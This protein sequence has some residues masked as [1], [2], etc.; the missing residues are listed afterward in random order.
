[1]VDDRS[2][3]ERVVT[4]DLGR[5][6]GIGRPLSER[7]RQTIRTV[8]AYLKGGDPPRWMQRL[9]EIDR[10]IVA[11]RQ[12]LARAYRALQRDCGHDAD[13]FACRWL[14]LAQS[15]KFD[16]LNELIG[17]HNDWYPIER[18]LP[19]DPRTGDYVKIAGR[20]YRRAPLGPAWVLQHFPASTPGDEG[21]RR[22]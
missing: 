1:M 15:W 10:G 6:E 5:E 7:A 8:E 2:P 3:A 22:R 9:R 12:R 11:E 14:A 19:M 18:D 17:Q 20:S 13:L 4:R 16:H 21:S